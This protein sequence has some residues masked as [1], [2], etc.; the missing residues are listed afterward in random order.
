M[1]NHSG[2]LAPSSSKQKCI[3]HRLSTLADHKTVATDAT[4]ASNASEANKNRLDEQQV[5]ATFTSCKSAKELALESSTSDENRFDSSYVASIDNGEHAIENH[6]SVEPRMS[7]T[8][9]LL[10]SETNTTAERDERGRRTFRGKRVIPLCP[11]ESRL[12]DMLLQDA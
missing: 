9:S 1:S 5:A 7:I 3:E 4:L 11:T 8:D 12:P 10:F 2:L 6:L